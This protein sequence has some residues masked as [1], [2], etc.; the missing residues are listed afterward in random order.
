L[1][2]AKVN[3]SVGAGVQQISAIGK[4]IR[5]MAASASVDAVRLSGVAG[6][7]LGITACS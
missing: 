2:V 4:R 6:H 5:A 1:R 3:G 7:I